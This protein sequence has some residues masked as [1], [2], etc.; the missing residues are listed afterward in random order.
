MATSLPALTDDVRKSNFSDNS[1]EW[2]ETLGNFQLNLDLAE[3]GPTM[4]PQNISDVIASS[5]CNESSKY[6][7]KENGNVSFVIFTSYRWVIWNWD[8]D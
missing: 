1:T 8:C 7:M 2:K 4:S 6:G 3:K 5:Y